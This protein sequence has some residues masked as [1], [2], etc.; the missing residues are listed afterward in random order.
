MNSSKFHKDLSTRTKV[1]AANSGCSQV[2]AKILTR[3]SQN[4]VFQK[5]PLL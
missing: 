5:V 3:L 1:T 2:R 4:D